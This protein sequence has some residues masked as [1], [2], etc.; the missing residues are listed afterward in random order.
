[1]K[2]LFKYPTVPIRFGTANFDNSSKPFGKRELARKS[3][4]I[5]D[6]S[7]LQLNYGLYQHITIYMDF[8]SSHLSNTL[9]HH[10][11]LSNF[12]TRAPEPSG[13]A[14]ILFR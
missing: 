13:A 4:V 8:M 6:I 3:I 11:Y 5:Y 2:V 9:C 14:F 12:S 1:M 7:F 10:S